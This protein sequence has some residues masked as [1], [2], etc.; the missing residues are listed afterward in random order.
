MPKGV[1]K[2]RVFTKEFKEKAV[3]LSEK[4]EKPICRIAEDLGVHEKQLR[5]WR[6]EVAVAKEAGGQ[7]FPG[8]G[9]PKNN[10]MERLLKENKALREDNKKLKQIIKQL[11]NLLGL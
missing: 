5:L 2:R 11:V 4:G 1:Y 9:Q 3:A 6:R 7:A 8:Y 10:E